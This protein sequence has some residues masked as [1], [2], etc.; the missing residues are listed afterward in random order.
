M[1]QILHIAE[2]FTREWKDNIRTMSII[3]SV[4]CVAILTWKCFK[5]LNDKSLNC[6]SFCWNN[7]NILIY[8]TNKS[9]ERFCPE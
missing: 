4:F 7:K 8:T 1:K 2:I 6:E 5:D 3:N 9:L